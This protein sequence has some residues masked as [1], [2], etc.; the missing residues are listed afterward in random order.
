MFKQ[1]LYILVA[2]ILLVVFLPQVHIFLDYIG[3]AHV[4]LS[5]QLSY[6][7]AGGKI[8]Q[9]IR[10]SVVLF[11]VPVIAGFIPGGIY[12]AVKRSTMPYQA[13]LIWLLWVMLATAIALK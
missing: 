9:L 7:F 11:L 12:W 10:H 3:Q 5:K 8:G 4:F 6:V 1:G 2:S 13:H